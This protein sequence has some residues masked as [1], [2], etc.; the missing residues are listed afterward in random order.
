MLTRLR[1]NLP[2]L[3]LRIGLAVVFGYAAQAS[4][5]HPLE[6]AGYL[7]HVL[8]ERADA[9]TLVK[10]LAVYEIILALWLLSGKYVRIAAALSAL[11]MAGILAANMSQLIITFRDFGLLCMALSLLAMEPPQRPGA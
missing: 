10:G 7:P 11:T 2:A 6:W 3:L 4:L 1:S 8:A 5:L 9:V